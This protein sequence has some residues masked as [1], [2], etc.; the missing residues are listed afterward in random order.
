MSHPINDK[1]NKLWNGKAVPC[2]SQCRYWKYPH[3]DTAC[4]LSDVF[5]VKKGEP[6]CEFEPLPEK[7]PEKSS[8]AG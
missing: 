4:I 1:L 2:N 5:S 7:P 6:C 8:E 3:L